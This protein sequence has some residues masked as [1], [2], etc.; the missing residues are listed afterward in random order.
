[1]LIDN[2]ED[3]LRYKG[4]DTERYTMAY[5]FP[6]KDNLLEKTKSIFYKTNCKI[7]LDI[8]KIVLPL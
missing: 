5:L 7:N 2:P 4:I 8:Q 3:L 6:D 1:M